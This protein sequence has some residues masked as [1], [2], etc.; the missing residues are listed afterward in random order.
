MT[1]QGKLRGIMFLLNF[2]PLEGCRYHILFF[3][4]V[5]NFLGAILASMAQYLLFIQR[6]DS[7]YFLLLVSS[8]TMQFTLQ[9]DMSFKSASEKERTDKA[10]AAI[11]KDEFLGGGVGVGADKGSPIRT[12]ENCGVDPSNEGYGIL[13]AAILSCARHRPYCRCNCLHLNKSCLHFSWLIASIGFD[14]TF[15]SSQH[16]VFPQIVVGP[17]FSM[18]Y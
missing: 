11:S 8:L 7:S 13:C 5:S 1:C 6:G 14:C 9:V 15:G 18:T 2:V 17:P 16:P 10:I 12:V 4:A 3:A